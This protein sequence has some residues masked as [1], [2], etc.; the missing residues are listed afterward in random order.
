MDDHGVD[1]DAP[2]LR[3]LLEFAGF[4]VLPEHELSVLLSMGELHSPLFIAAFRESLGDICVRR[5]LMSCLIAE[6]DRRVESRKENHADP[7]ED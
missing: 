5:L 2:A 6:R 3:E 7:K 4:S 1:A